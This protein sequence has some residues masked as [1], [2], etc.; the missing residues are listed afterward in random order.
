MPTFVVTT[1][2]DEND[3]GASVGSPQGAGLS[4][5]EALALANAG[6]TI[7]FAANLV[8]GTTAGVDDGRLVL[9]QGALA[10]TRDV[11]IEGDLN[12]DHKADITIDGN[13]DGG[14][15]AVD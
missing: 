5:R 13:H 8:G 10:I 4:L 2:V 11:T 6:D 1:L 3:T 15:L 12:G 9:T 7:T 14:V